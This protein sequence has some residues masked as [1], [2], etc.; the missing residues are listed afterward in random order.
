MSPSYTPLSVHRFCNPKKFLKISISYKLTSSKL[1]QLHLDYCLT[2]QQLSRKLRTHR[3]LWMFSFLLSGFRSSSHCDLWPLCTASFSNLQRF[4]V[5]AI[6]LFI[7]CIRSPLEAASL[8]IKASPATALSS[9][10]YLSHIAKT[11]LRLCL[12]VSSATNICSNVIL[13]HCR[14]MKQLSS[15]HYQNIRFHLRSPRLKK[16]F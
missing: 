6:N 2:S 14:C 13:L 1:F 5:P 8:N 12:D 15:R 9:F 3:S 4:L 16:L 11:A 10:R 7:A